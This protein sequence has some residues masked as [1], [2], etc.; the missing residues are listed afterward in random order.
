MKSDQII[1]LQRYAFVLLLSGIASGCGGKYFRPF[2]H[3]P[4]ALTGVTRQA[5]GLRVE[6][7]PLLDRHSCQTN[8]GMDCLQKGILPVY[9]MASNGSTNIS[10]RIVSSSIWFSL[11]END[12]QHIKSGLQQTNHSAAGSDVAIAGGVLGSIAVMG[13]SMKLT[14]DEES[15]RENFVIKQ[16]QNV[17]L[18]PG[19]SV[20]GFVYFRQPHAISL[21]SLPSV[22]IPVEDLQSQITNT[23]S[24]PLNHGP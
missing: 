21:D 6:V 8:F 22:N 13:L 11:R 2:V 1:K 5:G 19:K 20:E 17:N 23:I 3:N 9:L 7:D 4:A 15:V 12:A 18:A 10:Y 16:F 24:L 14:D